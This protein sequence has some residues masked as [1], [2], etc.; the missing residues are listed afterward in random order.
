MALLYG[1]RIDMISMEKTTLNMPIELKQKVL[2][3]KDELK[4]SMSAI[5][6]QAIEEFVKKQ[7][8]QKWIKAAKIMKEEY[9]NNP[10]L[11]DWIEF[12]EDIYDTTK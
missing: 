8:E 1:K 6:I 7:E 10:E 2:E 11:K 4:L 5:Y 9:E 12:E 3:L